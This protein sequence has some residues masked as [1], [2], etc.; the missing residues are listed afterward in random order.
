M[1][2]R[3]AGRMPFALIAVVALM[4]ASISLAYAGMVTRENLISISQERELSRMNILAI[5][6]NQELRLQSE[7]AALHSVRDWVFGLI[8][9][10][11]I[12]NR[13]EKLMGDDLNATFP[14]DIGTYTVRILN[15]SSMIFPTR[16][17]TIEAV[18]Y[19]T[20]TTI[21]QDNTSVDEI[22]SAKSEEWNETTETVS[23]A[24]VGWINYSIVSQTGIELKRTQTL[25]DKV[26]TLAPF[27]E[28]RLEDVALDFSDENSRIA[29]ILRY[30]LGTIIQLR[31]IQ[32]YG[33]GDSGKGNVEDILTVSDIET[34]LNVAIIL[35]EVR[36]FR[37]FDPRSV[38]AFPNSIENSTRSMKNLLLTYLDYGTV[39]PMD[40][41]ALNL[42]LDNA[43]VELRQILAQAIAAM[44][45]QYVIKY[46]DYFGLIPLADL[47][48]SL[49]ETL[50]N[51]IDDFLEWVRGEGKEAGFVKS[52]AKE[53]FDLIGQDSCFV[54]DWALRIPPLNFTVEN[55][56]GSIH[57][58][59]LTPWTTLADF[60]EKDLFDGY[61]SL[62]KDYFDDSYARD[63]IKVHSGAR[64]LVKDLS[65]KV[66]HDVNLTG[67][68]GSSLLKGRVD[69]KDNVSIL[70]TLS[71]E[72][73][74]RIEDAI[75]NM[76][77]NSSYLDY[78][79]GNVWERQKESV[80]H[81]KEFLVSR[82]DT[83]ADKEPQIKRAEE[84]LA[85]E[86]LDRARIEAEFRDLD[87]E[88]VSDLRQQIKDVVSES[89]WVEKAYANMKEHGN[90][91]L[92]QVYEKVS[93]VEA[94]PEK[95]GIYQGIRRLV[96][97]ANGLLASVEKEVQAFARGILSSEDVLNSKFL[98]LGRPGEFEFWEG[99]YSSSYENRSIHVFNLSVRQTPAYLSSSAQS[100]KKEDLE[101]GD[102]L[103]HVVDPTCFSPLEKT[104]N[105]HYTEIDQISRRPYQSGWKVSVLGRIH[106]SVESSSTYFLVDGA[107]H[108]ERL[109]EDILID[110]HLALAGY[111]GWPLRGVKYQGSSSFAEDIWQS[112]IDFLNKV[113]EGVQ[114]ILDWVIDGVAKILDI[115]RNVL[116]P[117]LDFAGKIVKALSEAIEITTD[118]FQSAIS[119]A[120]NLL[121]GLIEKVI[122]LFG[123]QEFS[124]YLLGLDI[125]VS[126]NQGN[127]SVVSLT[128]HNDGFDLRVDFLNL[129][130][131]NLTGK[132]GEKYDLLAGF[133]FSLHDFSFNASFDPLMAT[134]DRL[135]RAHGKWG[136][137][138]AMDIELPVLENITEKKYET[139]IP[140]IPTPLGTLDFD[141]GME[142]K[143]YGEVGGLD[144]ESLLSKAFQEAWNDTKDETFSLDLV[145]DF[146]K[147]LLHHF[148][149][150]IISTVE[151]RISRIKEVNFYIQGTFKVAGSA[152][153]G[154]GI[155]F[156]VEGPAIE[157]AFHWIL[158]NIEVFLSNLGNPCARAG[159]QELPR[160]VP[161]HL[162]LR[163]E[164]FFTVGIPH[165]IRY[166]EGVSEIRT[167][168][169]FVV[170][171]QA[172]IPAVASVF[173][174]GWGK[175][176]VDFGVYIDDL[177]APIAD[178]LFGTGNSEP[179]LWI[180][181]GK[182][183]QI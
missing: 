129:E 175:W 105:A 179:D 112:V 26:G 166:A 74:E 76:T 97:D 156:V 23:Y 51:S 80:A 1:I 174:L 128:V 152:G 101:T 133:G 180:L 114:T 66:A 182:I 89:S 155:A 171:I 139:S 125:L 63:L 178:A 141:I 18:D 78:M 25:S 69:P 72:T 8:N 100:K 104:P 102:L 93:S 35:E 150:D 7:R 58:I 161:E 37:G 110:I 13:F 167:D 40:I 15:H 3:S 73:K 17:K 146:A 163:G 81:L 142:V 96:L 24:T 9:R 64:D 84:L 10:T 79:I 83:I 67:I 140:S 65:E 71:R 54:H 94:P 6:V 115:I 32:G 144:I 135:F 169:R 99:N 46:F 121:G 50:A 34:A 164:F 39:D 91:S 159:Y 57:N 16:S 103:I 92:E 12:N 124:I 177:P 61:N 27:V 29:R 183:Y 117:L 119:G 162:F 170:T 116:T 33:S 38:G 77:S 108:P 53:V 52:W 45:D 87:S 181:K 98:A 21:S 131:R 148:I 11:E 22:D 130:E 173:G 127:G 62:W 56:D 176:Q 19:T 158:R 43:N 151:D 44:G 109:E 68:L 172:N 75:S 59:S 145:G 41:V 106:L 20:T 42:G 147:G 137:Q 49:K 138:W 48:L 126:L 14:R 31:I 118:I 60:E 28:R 120:T 113:W 90:V 153:A 149:Q 122:S 55:A 132:R 157:Y 2:K 168:Y 85:Q 36:M 111:S 134:S 136:D 30:I 4:L 123:P 143:S 165:M 95:G 160:E 88:G 5:G 47:G 154:V 107:P 70:E 82:F 86:I